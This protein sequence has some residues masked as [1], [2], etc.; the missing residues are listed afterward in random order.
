[1]SEYEIYSYEA[2]RKRTRDDIRTVEGSKFLLIDE[3]RMGTYLEDVKSERKN[4]ADNVGDNDIL[5]LMGI[6]KDGVPTL[7]GLMTFSKYPQSYFPQLCITAVALPGTEQGIVGD[8]GE[9]FIDNKRITGA[10]ETVEFVRKN[11]RTKT[12]FTI[13]SRCITLQWT[14]ICLLKAKWK[15]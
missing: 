9:R 14:G 2:F 12:I 15:Y 3:K 5:E 8:D 10:M 13:F 6:V 11:S 4:L 7:A 1:M